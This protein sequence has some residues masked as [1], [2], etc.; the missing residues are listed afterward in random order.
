VSTGDWVRLVTIPFFTGVIGWLINWTALL[1][2][3]S[4]V[5]L[6]GVAVPGLQ[7]LALIAPRKVQEIPGLMDG[8]LGWQGI[9]PARAAKMGSIAVDKAIAKIA[10]PA[11]FYENLGPDAIAQHIVEVLS[12]EVPGVVDR[13]M[14]S[15]YP[16]LWLNLPEAARQR[17]YERVREQLPTIITHV[18]DEIGEHIDLLFD[19]K[20]MVIDHFA[21]NPSLVNRIFQD[22]GRRELRLMVNFGFIFGFALGIPVAIITHFIEVWW[23][24]PILGVLVGWTTNRLGMWVIFEPTDPTRVGPFTLQGL[25][26]RRQP[27]VAEVYAEIVADEVITLENIAAFL[28]EGPSSDR[29]WQIIEDALGPAIDLA[30]GPGHGAVRV[31]VGASEYESIRESATA[32]AMPLT[33]EPLLDADFSRSRSAKIRQLFVERTAA[34][35]SQDFVEMLRSA[36]REDEWMLYLHGAVMGFAGGIIHLLIFGV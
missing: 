3:F 8:K 17:I 5:K 22:V 33:V 28:L 32:A 18:T 7:D 31:A 36:F 21:G 19:P 9:V 10:T 25:F 11:E 24:L 26:L 4:P 34:L 23:L 20:L 6:R 1:M 15:E 12:P 35:P 29:T 16:K 14:R 2:M 13:T 27:Q 30:L